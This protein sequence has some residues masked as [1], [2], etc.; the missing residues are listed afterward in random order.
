VQVSAEDG[1]R[2]YEKRS[3]RRSRRAC[4]GEDAIKGTPAKD[5][6]DDKNAAFFAK[7][8]KIVLENSGRIDPERIE[9]CVAEGAYEALQKAVTEMTPLDVIHRSRPP[10]A[11]TGRRRLPDG[12]QVEHRLQGQGRQEVRDLQRR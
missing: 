5:L 6:L 10:A 9:S 4:R 7:Q 11:G 12:A 8:R 3:M 1:T 2:L